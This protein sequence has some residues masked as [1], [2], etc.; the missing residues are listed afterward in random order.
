MGGALPGMRRERGPLSRFEALWECRMWH[1]K[2][3][4]SLRAGTI[5][6]VSHI[7]LALWLTAIW[8]FA[9]LSQLSSHE[10]GRRLGIT[11]ESAQSMVR[12]I[13]CALKK[14]EQQRRSQ[15]E[16]S[17]RDRRSGPLRWE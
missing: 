12:R 6:K 4:F 1:P 5:L 13:K 3:Q 14:S 8:M 15:L 11:Q 10:A 16:L 17:V 9:N 7:P 2:S